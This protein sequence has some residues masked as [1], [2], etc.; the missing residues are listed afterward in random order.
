MMK[1]CTKCGETKPISEFGKHK[2]SKDGHAWR[3]LECSIKNSQEYRRT[4]AGVYQIL[5]GNANFFQ[6]CTVEMTR[7]E[8]IDW[9][10]AE[11]KICAYCDMPETLINKTG[12]VWNNRMER[13]EVDRIDNNIGYTLDNMVLAC[14]RCNMIKS[15]YF[16]YEEMREIAQKYVKPK[17]KR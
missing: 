17:W 12:D 11:S 6:K 16:T 13:L 10:N 4:P 8:F 9:Y 5:C 7:S 15:D 14:P 1:K 3:C 2:R